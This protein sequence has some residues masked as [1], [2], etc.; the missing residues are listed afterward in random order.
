MGPR[1]TF[2]DDRLVAVA[3]G[4][5]PPVLAAFAVATAAIVIGSHRDNIERLVAGTERKIG[6]RAGPA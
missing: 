5:Q 4:A 1:I 2:A 6:Q 3:L